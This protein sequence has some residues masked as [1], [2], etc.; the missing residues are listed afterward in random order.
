MRFFYAL[1][2]SKA[3]LA[4]YLEETKLPTGLQMSTSNYQAILKYQIT[5]YSFLKKAYG[6]LNNE[7]KN[8][9]VVGSE[10]EYIKARLFYENEEFDNA[11]M[12]FN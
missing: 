10:S 3:F 6:A 9:Q 2:N 12:I 7:C 11:L 1:S 8:E 4:I 5:E